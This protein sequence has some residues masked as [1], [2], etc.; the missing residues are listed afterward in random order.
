MLD[1]SEKYLCHSR[2]KIGSSLSSQLDLIFIA[3]KIATCQ[4]AQLGCRTIQAFMELKTSS[5]SPGG[6]WIATK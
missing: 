5:S 4:L 6:S 3:D 2:R 1:Y